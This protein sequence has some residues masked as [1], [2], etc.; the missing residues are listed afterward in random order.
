MN[1]PEGVKRSEPPGGSAVEHVA[2]FLLSPLFLQDALKALRILASSELAL[3][4]FAVRTSL[5]LLSLRCH[6]VVECCLFV[7]VG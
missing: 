3:F 1:D 7:V 6:Q 2:A 5:R 4:G